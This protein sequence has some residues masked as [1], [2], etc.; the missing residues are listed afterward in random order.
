MREYPGKNIKPQNHRDTEA[1]SFYRR[2]R[3]ESQSRAERFRVAV[4]FVPVA[5]ALGSLRLCG[6]ALE[7]WPMKPILFTLAATLFY[8]VYNVLLELKFARLNALT[9]MIVYASVIWIAAF[10]MR[11]LVKTNDPS[12]S[13]PTGT[14][15]FL[16]IGL[17]L[18][19]AAGDYFFVSAYNSGG[20]V[21]TITCITLLIPVLA[22]LMRFGVTKSLPNMWQ[23]SG[24]V[25]AAGGVVLVAK[26]SMAK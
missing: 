23:V 15:L 24:Y 2:E 14:M 3:K 12:F 26:G 10:G 20:D 4:Q 7:L 22:S 17:G 18:I 21:V 13:F 8:A 6:F 16:A 19:C 5:H 1:Q 11:Q 9:L 25:L